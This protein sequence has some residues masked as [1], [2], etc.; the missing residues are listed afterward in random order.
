MKK[1]GIYKLQSAFIFLLI[2]FHDDDV[3]KNIGLVL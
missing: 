1:E 3:T 2:H